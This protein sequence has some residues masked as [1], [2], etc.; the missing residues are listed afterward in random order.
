MKKYHQRHGDELNKLEELLG[1]KRST[2]V[3]FIFSA[4]DDAYIILPLC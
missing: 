3:V 4:R 1:N 2:G